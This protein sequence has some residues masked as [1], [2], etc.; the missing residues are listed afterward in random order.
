MAARSVRLPD[1]GEGV[2]EAEVTAWHVKVGDLVR[3]D[4]PLADVMTDK[5]TVEIPSPVTGKVV[6]LGAEPG[7]RV[8]VG[9]E[10]VRLE[11][12]GEGGS[13]GIEV[14]PEI[15]AAQGA[16]SGRTPAELQPAA[17]GLEP[18]QPAPRKEAPPT[19]PTP[20]PA[21]PAAAPVRPAVAPPAG[22]PRAPGEKPIASPAVRR[23]A[24]EGGIDLRR[25]RGT[26][27]AGRITHDDLDAYLAAGESEALGQ[28][29]GMRPRIGVEEVKVVGLRRRIAENMADAKR[30]V[31]HFSY[32]EEVDVTA[33]EELRGALNARHGESRTRLTL[34]PFLVR[35]LVRTL[36]DFPQMN[37]LYDD[38]ASIVLRH[39]GVHV[40]I[41]TQTPNGLMVPVLRHAEARDLW[42]VAAELK[43]VADAARSGVAARDELSGS[44]ISITS[45]GALGGIATTPVVNRPEVAIIGVNKQVM[46]P[47]WRDGTFVPRLMMNLSSSFDHRVVDGYDAA[48]FIQAIKALLETPTLLFMD[49]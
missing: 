33:L 36:P 7:T 17:E 5:A 29:A 26:G 11:V 49:A 42:D 35:A 25:L 6:A 24:L 32:V 18:P 43:R 37:A 12:D 16:E 15:A 23:R 10:L 44:T 34:I 31:A 45:L 3:E 38:E 21:R 19:S 46:R 1:I 9:S 2:A 40:G 20:A 41:A 8:P 27:P 48:R 39:E 13:A 22:P 47:V 14:A 28:P 4:Q 30:R